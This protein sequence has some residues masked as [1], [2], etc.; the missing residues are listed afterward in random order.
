MKKLILFLVLV[1]TF[2]STSA[3]TGSKIDSMVNDTLKNFH[4]NIPDAANLIQR[5]KG[6]LVFP[7]VYKAGVFFLGGEYGQGALRIGGRTVDYYST[8]AGAVGLQLGAQKKS[9]IVLFL[10]QNA[11][12]KFRNSENWEVG[13]DASVAVVDVGLGGS[14][15]STQLNKPIVAFVLDQKGLM[16]NLTLEG[17]KFTKIQK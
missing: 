6:V 8:A 15:D 17:T 13:V 10:D 7:K 2:Q 9:I 16:Y 12:N 1:L 5:S 3:A 11:L 4:Q 14:I